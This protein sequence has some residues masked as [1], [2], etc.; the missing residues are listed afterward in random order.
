MQV[1]AAF[2]RSGAV[3]FLQVIGDRLSVGVVD[4]CAICLDH[5]GHLGVPAG[6]IQEYGEFI[7]M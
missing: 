5:L 7:G 6:G 2:F 1:G 3:V 4:R